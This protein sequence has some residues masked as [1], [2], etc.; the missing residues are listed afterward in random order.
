M[1]AVMVMMRV[2]KGSQHG[3]EQAIKKL[4]PDA[5]ALAS[6]SFNV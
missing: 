5:R 1:A 4:P 2:A 6:F 3:G